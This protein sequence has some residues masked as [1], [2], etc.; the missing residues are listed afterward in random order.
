MHLAIADTMREKKKRTNPK[1]IWKTYKKRSIFMKNEEKSVH[2]M[3]IEIHIG[4]MSFVEI[5]C[6]IESIIG[7][8]DPNLC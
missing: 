3:H 2:H 7:P 1:K 6:I 8:Q 5:D 4:E